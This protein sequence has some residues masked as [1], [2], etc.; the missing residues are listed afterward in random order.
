MG[1]GTQALVQSGHPESKAISERQAGLEHLVRSLQRRSNLRRHRLME[2]LFRHEY[3]LESA[4]LEQWIAEQMQHAS[5]E[6]YG[7]DYEH[8]QILQAKFDDFKH[9]IEAGSE[10]I[11]QCDDLAQKL[12]ANESPYVT[13]IEMKQQ[14]LG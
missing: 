13:D 14:Q 4:E 7:Q 12:I 10:R 11:R 1:R 8:L 2:S 9:K 3:F 6:D 5:S